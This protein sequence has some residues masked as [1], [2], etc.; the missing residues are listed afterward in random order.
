[1]TLP[2]VPGMVLRHG[3][4]EGD[5]CNEHCSYEYKLIP[6]LKIVFLDLVERIKK[7]QR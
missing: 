4:E 6:G 1:M 2:Q 5:L 3:H 7:W